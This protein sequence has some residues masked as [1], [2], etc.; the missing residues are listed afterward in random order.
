MWSSLLATASQEWDGDEVLLLL[1]CA[2]LTF[3][4][5]GRGAA[6]FKASSPLRGGRGRMWPLLVATALA[7]AVLGW[8]TW[9]W[10]AREI[11]HG[12][13]YA[14]L[15]MFMGTAWL[16]LCALGFQWLGL[17]I[18]D[19]VCERGNHAA[20]AALSGAMLGA[21]CVYAGAITGEGPSFWNNVFS[22]GVGGIVWFAGWLILELFAQASRNVA[23]ERDPA[24]GL[25][26][27]GYLFASGLLIGRAVAGNWRGTIETV[28]DL[29]RDG[30]W[31]VPLAGVAIIGEYF[32]R[33]NPTSP[34]PQRADAW[35]NVRSNLSLAC[36]VA[37]SSSRLVGRS[38]ALMNISL[39]PPTPRPSSDAVLTA[40]LSRHG[41]APTLSPTTCSNLGLRAGAALDPIEFARIRRHV[42]LEGCKWDPQVGDVC[43]LAHFPLLLR[44]SVWRQLALWT[45]E[46]AKE[47]LSAEQ[48]ILG[49]P[50]L[51]SQLGL[52]GPICRALQT[53]VAPTPAALR[54]MRFDFHPTTEGWRI[55]EVN[56]DVPGGY[57]ESTC[58]TE[59][60]ARRYSCNPPA[61]RTAHV[62]ADALARHAMEGPG[63]SR[64]TVALLAAP[65]YMEDQQIIVYL[66][67]L[68]RARGC[69]TIL[70]RPGQVHWRNDL[71]EVETCTGRSPVAAVV[72][73]YQAEWL[74][75]LP[76]RTGWFRYFRGSRTPMVNPGTAV[77]SESK[78]FPIVWD[79]L[80]CPLNRW[81]ALLP[82]T[83]ETTEARWP[84]DDDWIVKSALCNTG[85][86]V[87]LRT[88]LTSREWQRLRWEV[89]LQPRRWLAQRR[90]VSVPVETP[91]G[92]LHPCIGIYAI[93]GR[94]TG[95]Y[96]RLAPKPLINYAAIDAALLLAED[97]P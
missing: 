50:E 60:F 67:G 69:Q 23:E 97:Y 7:I 47:T 62:W 89:W 49:R 76:W 64:G 53:D 57:T 87:G 32:L 43:T 4:G 45:E 19:D 90:F 72:R 93:N 78:R 26:L 95:A 18:R 29:L 54:I 84:S 52:P 41:P 27:G 92:P 74:A 6:A 17:S 51:L 11:R 91:L 44:E 75:R 48:E 71:A 35:C 30:W 36:G 94:A 33:P 82:E 85:D 1:I 25:R 83:R 73:F 38:P 14:L 21:T 86:D 79:R 28:H 12:Q 59:E 81:R 46:L 56:S 20:S 31:I 40:D 37:G 70:G 66:A 58:F 61:G 34:P 65:G 9:Q 68:L 88:V 16:T 24:S 55:S 5:V 80:R 42:A 96:A 3:S 63:I 22:A 77:I 2:G 10:T 15:T 13:S 39:H 8:V